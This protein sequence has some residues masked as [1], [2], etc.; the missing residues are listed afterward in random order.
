[1]TGNSLCPHIILYEEESRCWIF[2]LPLILSAPTAWWQRWLWRRLWRNWDWRPRL[3]CSPWSWL[4][5]PI[6]GWIPAMMRT[7]KPTIRFLRSPAGRWGWIWSC[8]R[9][10]VPGLT[11]GWPL[12]DIFMPRSREGERCTA[13]RFTGRILQMK[14]ISATWTCCMSWQG[15]L[16][17]TGRISGRPL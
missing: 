3:P 13:I 14:R 4:R 8:R 9:R 5:S 12:R 11:P 7:G 2:Y 17:L 16:A 15:S 10:S 6:P 1:M